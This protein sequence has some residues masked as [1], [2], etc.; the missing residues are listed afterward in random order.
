MQDTTSTLSD[1]LAGLAAQVDA[2]REPSH[3]A[4]LLGEIQEAFAACKRTEA[5]HVTFGLETDAFPFELAQAELLCLRLEYAR[6]VERVAAENDAR[7]SPDA[8]D[9]LRMRADLARH[10][11]PTNRTDLESIRAGR[12]ARARARASAV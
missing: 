5:R 8:L 6:L 12:T 1:R 9:E 3:M 2:A 10:C 4:A 7:L 11:P